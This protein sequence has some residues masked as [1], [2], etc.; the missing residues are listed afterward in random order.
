MRNI[1]QNLLF[2]FAYNALGI[3]IAAGVLYSFFGLVL[4]PMIAAA[5]MSFSSVSAVGSAI[6]LRR[7]R[8]EHPFSERVG[9][10]R[11]ESPDLS[12]SSSSGRS[13]GGTNPTAGERA[14]A[15]RS[16]CNA[17]FGRTPPML[18]RIWPPR[19][20]VQGVRLISGKPASRTLRRHDPPC[21]RYRCGSNTI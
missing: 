6:R 17:I 9:E 1:Q 7:A 4:S 19:S 10:R 16:L 3:P 21:R 12:R 2:V 18:H 15:D 11:R 20:D 8:F 14:Y 13:E 5:A